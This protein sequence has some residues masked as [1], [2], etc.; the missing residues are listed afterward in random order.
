MLRAVSPEAYL[1]AE[2]A[3]DVRHEY[4][5]GQVYALAG[6]RNAHTVI[7]VNLTV[8]LG[9]QRQG[10]PCQVFASATKLRAAV[11]RCYYPDLMVYCGPFDLQL[12]YL[13]HP[14]YVFE[15]TSPSSQR[16]DCNEKSEACRRAPSIE[17]YVIVAQDAMQ[18]V[19]HR[20]AADAEAD[21]ETEILSRPEDRLRL[22]GIGFE[23]DLAA[24]YARAG[25]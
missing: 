12:D 21:W 24:I 10:R 13:E 25:L 22:D 3:A 5:R 2:R 15:V 7:A 18:V 23:C 8:R 17:A 19:V 16:I 6:T 4:V 9:L 1:E 11:D 14:R 20:R